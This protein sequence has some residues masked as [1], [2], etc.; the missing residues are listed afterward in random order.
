VAGR[1]NGTTTWRPWCRR[2]SEILWFSRT[3]SSMLCRSVQLESVSSPRTNRENALTVTQKYQNG[4]QEVKI[5][6]TSPK[7]RNHNS[8]HTAGLDRH[9]PQPTQSTTATANSNFRLGASQ[10]SPS[11]SLLA[12]ASPRFKNLSI[13]TRVEVS[14]ASFKLPTKS[15]GCCP[16]RLGRLE[17]RGCSVGSRLWR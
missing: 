13:G 2:I 14:P 1:F 10:P 12:L 5:D 15:E 16:R 11:S 4:W 8:P 17:P 6:A 9:L 3:S 7:P